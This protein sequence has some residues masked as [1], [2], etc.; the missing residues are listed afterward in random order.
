M[1]KN[2]NSIQEDNLLQQIAELLRQLKKI[3]AEILQIK[4]RLQVLENP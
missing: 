2:L 3:E 1:D 4:K